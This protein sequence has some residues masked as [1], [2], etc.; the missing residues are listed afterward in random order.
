M[1]FELGFFLVG[2]RGDVKAKNGRVRGYGC[3]EHV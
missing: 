3:V 2:E 1:Y